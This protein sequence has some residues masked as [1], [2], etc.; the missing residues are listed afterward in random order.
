VVIASPV[1]EETLCGRYG[2]WLRSKLVWLPNG[3]EGPR[4]P[5][6]RVE[7]GRAAA[8]LL[9][10]AL[11]FVY[12]GAMDSAVT[13]APFLEALGILNAR[14]PEKV[15]RAEVR[16]IGYG[17]PEIGRLRSIVA[18]YGLEGTVRF[19][20]ARSHEDALREQE[21]ADILLLFSTAAHRNTIT[22]KSFEYMRTGKPVLALIPEDGVQAGLLREANTAWIVD[23]GDTGGVL[24]ALEALLE[25]AE[26]PPVEPDWGYIRQFDR[27]LLAKRLARMLDAV[28]GAPSPFG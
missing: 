19:L 4:D 5:A 13:P 14:S 25:D 21:E 23:H 22:G 10:G 2:G 17:G 27:R 8:P 28:V 3:F 16:L 20:G 15:A 26:V 1:W 9:P 18:Q 12:T 6:D 11:R 7:E 24:A